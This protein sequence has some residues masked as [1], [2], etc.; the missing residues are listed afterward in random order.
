[1]FYNQYVKIDSGRG[2]LPPIRPES[3]GDCSRLARS[4]GVW[5]EVRQLLNRIPVEWPGF[6]RTDIAQPAP[7]RLHRGRHAHMCPTLGRGVAQPGSASH[8][9][10]GGRRFESCRPDQDHHTFTAGYAGIERCWRDGA[11]RPLSWLRPRRP[12]AQC[13][14]RIRGCRRFSFPAGGGK[15]GLLGAP[16]G[17]RVSRHTEFGGD[18]AIGQAL[19]AELLWV[20]DNVRV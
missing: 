3:G 7:R 20:F 12:V 2:D 5:S 11:W 13:G 18:F 19:S 4:G 16:A 15:V 8:W 1:M 10:C 6:G 14:Y 17:D 9:G